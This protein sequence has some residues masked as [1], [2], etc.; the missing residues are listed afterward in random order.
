MKENVFSNFKSFAQKLTERFK[1]IKK[2]R[3]GPNVGTVMYGDK[4]GIVH[5]FDEYGFLSNF[6]HS[7]NKVLTKIK[8]FKRPDPRKGWMSPRPWKAAQKLANKFKA[9]TKKV[10]I[11]VMAKNEQNMNEK[12]MKQL[13]NLMGIKNI[14]MFTVGIRKVFKFKFKYSIESG[15]VMVMIL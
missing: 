12:Q 5:C 2:Q 1:I 8:K 7:K 6:D 4:N 14:K 13:Y 3:G 15:P 10:L 11:M 9:G